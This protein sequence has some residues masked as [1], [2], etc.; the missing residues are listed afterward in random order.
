MTGSRDIQDG[1][2]LSG[3]PSYISLGRFKLTALLNKEFNISNLSVSSGKWN[4]HKTLNL[5]F[6][7]RL[8]F[9]VLWESIHD[10][11]E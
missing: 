5:H 4:V 6:T 1:R 2:I 9:R 7:R 3:Q 10:V 11:V 8:W